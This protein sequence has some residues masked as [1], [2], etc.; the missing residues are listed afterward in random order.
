M[1]F[2][3]GR[4]TGADIPQNSK[5]GSYSSRDKTARECLFIIG[6]H[7]AAIRSKKSL[8]IPSSGPGRG[9]IK[10][11]FLLGAERLALIRS[12]PRGILAVEVWHCE[13]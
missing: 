8:E 4:D 5:F 6:R 13:C 1:S 12:H 11:I 2:E 7:C 9:L 10:T 3:G